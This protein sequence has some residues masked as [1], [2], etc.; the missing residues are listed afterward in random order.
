MKEILVQVIDDAYFTLP[1][2]HR[3]SEYYLECQKLAK[4]LRKPTDYHAEDKYRVTCDGGID[5]I[6]RF[7]TNLDSEHG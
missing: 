5:A 6:A 7:F 2:E 3:D 4:R 1:S